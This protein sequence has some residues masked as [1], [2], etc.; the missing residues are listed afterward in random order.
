MQGRVQILMPQNFQLRRIA[1]RQLEAGWPIIPLAPKGKAPL[2]PGGCNSPITEWPKFAA[3]IG[4]HPKLNYGI[5]TGK[6]SG[7]I[8]IDIDGEAG[9]ASL[10]LLEAE[11]VPLP[12]TTC[13]RTGKGRHLYFISDTTALR[14]RNGWRPG[15]DVRANGGYI[16]GL[17]S[18]HASGE[19]Y[20]YAE[21][22]GPDD[23]DIAELPSW[24]QTM[25]VPT[26]P[27][28]PVE[29]PLATSIPEGRRNEELTRLA[30]R[31]H[32]TGI[33]A[34]ALLAALKEENEK[35]CTPPLV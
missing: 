29:P 14:N 5:V 20:R 1:R 3:Y 10:R 28:K 13:V 18:I 21:G 12:K 11:S 23:V 34:D 6:A 31:L 15:I 7:L 4:E 33:G 30:G 19:L 17:G 35:H 22:C 16:V 32:N 8:V 27:A 24:L 9:E 25:L 26:P 2:N